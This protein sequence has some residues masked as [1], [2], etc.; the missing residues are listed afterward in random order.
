MDVDGFNTWVDENAPMTAHAFQLA[1]ERWLG[2]PTK[3]EPQGEEVATALW[4]TKD[5]SIVAYVVWRRDVSGVWYP[6]LGG[7]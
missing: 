7:R 4:I 6:D 3:W 2:K 1:A 5:G